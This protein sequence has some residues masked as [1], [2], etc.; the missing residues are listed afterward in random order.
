MYFDYQEWYCKKNNTRDNLLEFP[1]L[2]QPKKRLEAERCIKWNNMDDE[3]LLSSIFYDLTFSDEEKEEK[4]DRDAES[5]KY[6]KMSYFERE[7]LS[8]QKLALRDPELSRN[9]YSYQEN[10]K[11]L[12]PFRFHDLI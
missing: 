9:K 1:F 10:E 6:L 8:P 11:F 3:R 4:V 5:N 2:T 12:K 7:R